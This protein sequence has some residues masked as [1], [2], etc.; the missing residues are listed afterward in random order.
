MSLMKN[1]ALASLVPQ[2]SYKE[3]QNTQLTATP[4]QLTGTP[5]QLTPPQPTTGTNPPPHPTNITNPSQPI[6]INQPL[7]QTLPQAHREREISSTAV[8]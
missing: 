1:N 4:T 2:H 3:I 8:T 5:P 7:L 6:K